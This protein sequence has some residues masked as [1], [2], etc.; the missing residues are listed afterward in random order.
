MAE[1]LSPGTTGHVMVPRITDNEQYKQID[2]FP[3]KD[4]SKSWAAFGNERTRVYILESI[5]HRGRNE[6]VWDK[7][8]FSVQR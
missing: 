6:Y 8:P 7:Q 4:Q 3:S 5:G 2:E 1:V